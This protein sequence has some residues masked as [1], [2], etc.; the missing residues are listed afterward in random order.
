M[1]YVSNLYKEKIYEPERTIQAKVSFELLDVLAYDDASFT[2]S[3]EAPISR[4]TQAIN[5]IR[6]MSHRYATFERDYFLLDGTSYIPPQEN[7]GDSELGWWSNVISDGTGSFAVQPYIEFTFTN[8]HNSVGLTL[9]FDKQANEY[10]ADFKIEAFDASDALIT[11]ETIF[12]NASP[13]YY[14]ETLLDGYKRLKI[15]ILKWGEPKRR[16]RLVEVDF[17][18]VREYTGDKLISLKIIEEMDLLSSTVP[19]NEMQFSLDNSDQSFNMLNP[20]GIYRFLKVNQEMTAQLG[21]LIGEEKYEYIP[22]GKYY[23]AEWTVEEGAMVATFI[24]RDWFNRLDAI[25]YTTLLQNTNLYDL[26]VSVLTQAKVENYTLDE[27]LKDRATFGFREALPVREALQ[28]I[29]IAGRCIVK[30]NRDGFIVIEQYT[31]L[32]DETGYITFAGSDTFAGMTTPQIQIDYAFQRIDFEAVY[33]IP[34]VSLAQPVT[35]LLFKMTNYAGVE[36]EAAYINEGVLEGVGY[37]INNPLINSEPHAA[38]VAEWMFENYDYIVEYEANWRQNPALECGDVI[39]IEDSF[40]N[41]KKSRITKQEYNFS[42]YL[43]GL[44]N[45]KGGV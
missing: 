5:K 9:T 24:G 8:P 40:N 23:L 7:Q 41:T 44:T 22:M 38:W 10:A 29:A 33:E 4:L 13:I 15:T 34:K 42:G 14:F 27:A 6:D 25:K 19:S 35:N 16:A 3:D 20:D 32:T 18:V 26:A 45:A 37:E 1:V 2:V 11:S 30:Q 28:M 12:A 39:V 21:L 36:F 43:D 31:E 17:G